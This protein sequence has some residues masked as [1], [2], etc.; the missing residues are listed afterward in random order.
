MSEL[1]ALQSAMFTKLTSKVESKDMWLPIVLVEIR[2]ANLSVKTRSVM[3]RHHCFTMLD[4]K[5]VR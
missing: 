1:Y 4:S 5:E 3:N 2:N